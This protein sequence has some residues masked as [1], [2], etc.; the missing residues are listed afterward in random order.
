[1]NLNMRLYQRNGI[2]YVELERDKKI[3]LKTKDKALAQQLFRKIKKDYLTRKVTV[4]GNRPPEKTLS[5]FAEEYL[6]FARKTMKWGT[7]RANRLALEKFI[8]FANGKTP[9]SSITRQHIDRWMAEQ[10]LS[11]KPVSANIRYRSLS[12]VFSKAVEW[13]YIKENPCKGVKQFSLIKGAPRYLEKKEINKILMAETDQRFR[14]L[15]LF[16][17][18][19]GVRRAEALQIE[20]KD[21]DWENCRVGVIAK[22]GKRRTVHLTPVLLDIIKSVGVQVGKLWPWAL[23]YVSRK[24]SQTAQKA[25]I[26]ARL[27]DLRHTFASYVLMSGE[28]IKV[29]KELLGH[30]DIKVTEIYAHL[31]E[32]YLKQAMGKLNF[33]E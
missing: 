22:T 16:Y 18:Y 19:S 27:H 33:E 8:E 31:S 28:D 1:M 20:A 3:S 14:L 11:I 7:F 5:E 26:K 32:G 10:T 30:T 17:L 9:L 23:D 13:G 21:I 25:G 15:W 4:I 12:S 6:D 2:W 29:V 24:F